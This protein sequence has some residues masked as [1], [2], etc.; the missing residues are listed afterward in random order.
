[1]LA[2]LGYFYLA[3]LVIATIIRS[4]ILFNLSLPDSQKFDYIFTGSGCAALSLLARMIQS[5]KFADKKILLIDK[6]SKTRN[7]RTWCFWEKGS[8]F[9]EE[10][11]YRKWPVINFF[12]DTFSS[13]LDIA[14]YQYKMI[15]GIDFYNYCFQLI[16]EQK[17]IAIVYGDV[18]FENDEIFLNDKLLETNA[19]IVFNSIYRL[20]ATGNGHIH[21]HQHFKGWIIETSETAFDVNEATLM[22]FRVHQDHGTTFS[23]ILPLSGTKALVEYTLF[24]EQLLEPGQYD[25]GLKNYIREI[26]KITGYRITDEEVGVIPMSNTKFNFYENGRYNIGTAGGQTKASSG[27]TFRF[28]QE[29]SDKIM[30][31]LLA[32]EPLSGL[33]LPSKR[34]HFYDRILLRILKENKLKGS[35]I[36]S[37]LFARN[38]AP[39][40]FK[41]LDNETSLTE[42]LKIISSLPT[43]P[44]LKAALKK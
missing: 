19:A 9:F 44:F 5:G 23:Y 33:A 24:T 40:V 15:R 14:P 21:L 29:H 22:D 7:D 26:L 16:G 34:F 43:M 2:G 6:E 12:S 18:W 13:R 37:R 1:M 38:K 20:P 27:Y 4:V 28:I 41:F 39:Q 10:I 17:N 42:E 3:P 30:G 11:V 8:S 35:D 36:F 32:G 25:E 31:Q